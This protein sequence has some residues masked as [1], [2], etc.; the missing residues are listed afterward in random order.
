MEAFPPVSERH[1]DILVTAV[2]LGYD[3]TMKIFHAVSCVLGWRPP[4][5][6]RID[7]LDNR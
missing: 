2:P 6:E 3:K 5:G 4:P 1:E 7:R